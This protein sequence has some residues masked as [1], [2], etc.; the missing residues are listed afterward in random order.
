[1]YNI[2]IKNIV[3][4]HPDRFIGGALIPLQ[5]VEASVAELEWARDA[6]FKVIILDKVFPVTEHCFS[7]PLGS[8]R[9][10]WPFFQRVQELGMTTL[11]HSV[12][13]GHRTTN[14]MVYQM[15]GL[16]IF[17]T[18][19][20]HISMMSLVTSGLLDEIPDLKF[21]FTEAGTSFLEPLLK[22]FDTAF[23]SPPVD[24]DAE[25]AATVFN[26]R[27]LT[28]GKRLVPFDVYKAKNKE[29]PS[30]YFRRNFLFTIEPEEPG[31]AE[32]VKF[33]GASQFLF[34]TDYPH[35]DPG[36]RMKMKDVELLHAEPG[37]TADEKDMLF[38]RN[39]LGLIAH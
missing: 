19:E 25:D 39:A 6:G 17:A 32:S 7:V 24:Y 2:S 16:D 30:D 36:G 1:S 34:A 9:E 37:L 28:S 22:R 33:L 13:H 38:G 8:R 31:F 5:D 29:R 20:G 21:V 12:T 35:D 11:L 14:L 4:R 10:L 15:D 23:E 3:D 27:R 18:P 26:M